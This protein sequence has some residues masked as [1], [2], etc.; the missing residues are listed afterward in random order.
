[1]NFWEEEDEV[2]FNSEWRKRD[3]WKV[4]ERVTRTRYLLDLGKL[5]YKLRYYYRVNAA[6][7]EQEYAFLLDERLGLRKRYHYQKSVKTT[8]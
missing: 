8:L 4:K 2:T 1:V 5:T 7:G 3:G 6:T